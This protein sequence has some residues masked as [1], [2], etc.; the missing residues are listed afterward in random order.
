VWRGIEAEVKYGIFYGIS[1][2]TRAYWDIQSARQ[3]L[4]YEPEDNAEQYA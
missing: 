3:Q 4:G 2:N 1:G